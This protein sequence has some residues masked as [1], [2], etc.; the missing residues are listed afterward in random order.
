MTRHEAKPA[1]TAVGRYTL[2]AMDA[3]GGFAGSAAPK[4]NRGRPRRIDW[5]RKFLEAPPTS[6][7]ITAAAEVAGVSVDTIERER[8]RNATFAE[9]FREALDAVVERVETSLRTYATDGVLTVRTV[10]RSITT[11][12]GTKVGIETITTETLRPSV[13]AAIF[14]LKSHKP[15]TYRETTR[16]EGPVSGGIQLTAKE[17]AA[18]DRRIEKFVIRR[19]VPLNH[20]PSPAPKS[21]NTRSRRC[22]SFRTSS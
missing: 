9:A 15:E 8:E 13:T 6:G 17:S 18:L 16:F 19:R 10:T 3:S 5:Q 4:R 1:L 2:A 22:G 14:Y 21:A 12:A 20:G 11:E 7:Y